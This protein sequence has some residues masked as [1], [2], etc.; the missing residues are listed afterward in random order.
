MSGRT[1]EDAPVWD[2]DYEPLVQLM[3]GKSGVRSKQAIEVGRR[4]VEYIRGQDFC[5]WV[6]KN[7][8]LIRK[9]APL[10]VENIEL[11]SSKD[12][13]EL[14][15]RLI[16]KR[17]MYRAMAK[18][19]AKVA[20]V[21]SK[22]DTDAKESARNL[23][24]PKKVAITAN[25][26]F[27]EN[28]FYVICYEGSKTWRYAALA[29]IISAV[30]LLC[31]FPAWPLQVKIIVWYISFSMLTT[32]LFLMTLRLVTFVLL[33][34][35]G[36][37]FWIFP[38]LLNEEIGVVESFQPVWS[39][40]Y[41]K[42]EWIMVAARFV[43]AILLAAAVYQLNQT[44]SL[45]D[46]GNFTKQQFLDVLE[47]G[48]KKLE[49]GPRPVNVI[50]PLS[51]LVDDS[52]HSPENAP[53]VNTGEEPSAETSTEAPVSVEED[54]SC[55]SS[56]GYSTYHEV[57]AHCGLRCECMKDLLQP[58]C[59]STCNVPT[60]KALQELFRGVCFIEPPSFDKD[61]L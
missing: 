7:A 59:T 2:P 53:I 54:F 45:S 9:K 12:A 36:A 41:R 26:H 3:T 34:F 51:S 55:L 18:V 60:V 31:M 16:E 50:P 8:D 47:W 24:W 15:N 61:E 19:V 48:Q 10:A 23:K 32:I 33:W 17:F 35:L 58:K 13:V 42:D 43:C 22:E 44:H 37:D 56:C 30:L 14:G 4:A 52:P 57:D 46:I 25:Q 38:N 6:L 49:D 11:K 20:T 29:G 39:F 28:S 5:K 1:K 27:E 21:E 40:S